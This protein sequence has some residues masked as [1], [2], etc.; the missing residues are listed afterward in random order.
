MGFGFDLTAMLDKLADSPQVKLAMDQFVELHNGI[1]NAVTHFNSRFDKQDQFTTGFAQLVDCKLS[2]IEGK[3]DK[4]LFL[5]E[6][7]SD[8]APAGDDGLLKM[9]SESG[10]EMVIQHP[11]P[12][13]IVNEVEYDQELHIPA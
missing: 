13:P 9:L 8:V 11:E 7:P 6:H 4:I 2:S 10:E 5:L 12:M 3:C 1:I